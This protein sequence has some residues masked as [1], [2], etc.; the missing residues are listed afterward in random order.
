MLSG[1]ERFIAKI[2][3]DITT[4]GISSEVLVQRWSVRTSPF[5]CVVAPFKNSSSLAIENSKPERLFQ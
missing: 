1:Y 4:C 5:S 2:I 3:R